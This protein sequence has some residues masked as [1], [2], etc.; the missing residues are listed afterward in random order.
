MR[1]HT[2]L[3]AALCAIV[4]GSASAAQAQMSGGMAPLTGQD[5]TFA[6]KASM[7]NEGEISAG[8]LAMSMG[9]TST[10][11]ELG[12]RFIDNHT[13]NE[14]MLSSIASK[15][16]LTLPMM[17]SPMDKM[18][19]A[20]LKTLSGRAFDM[21]YLKAQQTGHE[22]AVAL[23]KQEIAN[24]TNPMLVAYAKKSLPVIE[25]HLQLA[26]DDAGKMMHMANGGM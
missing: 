6:M 13:T 11:R 17:P 10:V 25:E 1:Q 15:E 14:A 18:T 22:K 7:A 24:G 19:A 2:A 21:A 8:R 20:H 4:V 9:T 23:F 12:K 3:L 26:T 16:H 5:K